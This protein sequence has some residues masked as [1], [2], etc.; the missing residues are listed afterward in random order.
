MRLT[1]RTL[2]AYRDGVLNEEDRITLEAKLR[3]SSTARGISER[4]DASQKNPKLAPIPHDAKD[5]WFDAN[6]IA[7]YLDDTS[8]TEIVAEVE[9]R[10]LENNA[11]LSEVASCHSILSRAL[12][13]STEVSDALRARI[14]TL[15]GNPQAGITELRMERAPVPLQ[16]SSAQKGSG[17]NFGL[18][19]RSDSANE[20][21]SSSELESGNDANSIPASGMPHSDGTPYQGSDGINQ[22]AH[23]EANASHQRPTHSQPILH[24]GASPAKPTTND[25]P[26]K[27]TTIGAI[28]NRRLTP[29][30]DVNAAQ[31]K[32]NPLLAS[33]SSASPI[34]TLP[35]PRG[36]GIELTDGLGSQVPEYLRLTDRSRL[37]PILTAVSLLSGVVITGAL[38]LGS[39]E[40]VGE[41]LASRPKLKVPQASIPLETAR[42][43][44]SKAPGGGASGGLSANESSA[45][46]IAANNRQPSNPTTKSDEVE[47]S[48][49]SENKTVDSKNTN[50]TDGSTSQSPLGNGVVTVGDPD[51]K[52]NSASAG[53]NERDDQ[54]QDKPENNEDGSAGEGLTI[55]WTPEQ[56]S[57]N[58]Q[59]LFFRRNGQGINETR[60]QIVEPGVRLS[61]VTWVIPFVYRSSLSLDDDVK[62]LV[63]GETELQTPKVSDGSGPVLLM[64]Y[65]RILLF[66]SEQ[67]KTII[68]DLPA[69]RFALTFDD[70]SSVC[71]IETGTSLKAW[72]WMPSDETSS[73][74]DTER[75]R[76][77]PYANFIGVNGKVKL[78]FRGVSEEANDS[79][80]SL[81]V[82]DTLHFE[83][84]LWSK[85]E[86]VATPSWLK[87]NGE[88]PID[89][90]AVKDL[91]KVFNGSQVAKDEVLESLIELSQSRKAE[92]SS[93][94]TRI[95]CQF[96]YYESFASADGV[97]AKRGSFSHLSTWLNKLTDFLYSEDRV[98]KFVSSM[99]DQWGDQASAVVRFLLPMTNEQLAAGGDRLLVDA[100]GSDSLP[101]R[102]LAIQQLSSIAGGALGYQPERANADAI[103]EW[104]KKLEQGEIRRSDSK[105]GQGDN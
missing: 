40:T 67:S 100:L 59:I 21:H 53:M 75:I 44:S 78:E 18:G 20:S 31:S 73:S 15:P 24:S 90:L 3:E 71:A 16:S 48:K 47:S 72:E 61:N 19:E 62:L 69:G 30:K 91:A 10:C 82:G 88:R 46:S 6:L 77:S 35:E 66:P 23:S 29:G 36:R 93:L 33:S 32:G 64:N 17:A 13:D 12:N 56:P 51:V 104:K 8:P 92:S 95:L 68:L 60:W 1:L 65:G 55:A 99:E 103:S 70:S 43:G 34:Q 7:E 45:D 49:S 22:H 9:R 97:L 57:D 39:L 27:N 54:Q 86:L 105:I 41:L 37:K 74:L 26:G 85:D 76:M 96:G 102:V 38:A 89:L 25:L 84:S 14:K 81:D 83:D 87:S 28:D 63:C 79:A 94:A 58:Q 80:E 4:I 11:L 52:R 42:N 50:S 101:V 98:A 5:P 2:L